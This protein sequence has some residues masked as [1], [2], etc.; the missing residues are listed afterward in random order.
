[1]LKKIISKIKF[2]EKNKGFFNEFE[3][4]FWYLTFPWH[5][6]QFKR[7]VC[8]GM[9]DCTINLVSFGNVCEKSLKIGGF[10][11]LSFLNRPFWIFLF[12]FFL[13]HFHENQSKFLEY[14]GWIKIFMI[15]LASS[16]K[17]QLR[18][19]MQHSVHK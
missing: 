6:G 5:L 9:A 13:L 10:E 2:D 1:M 18:K 15:T 17:Q 16:P 3:K 4:N 11:N 7:K 14:Q 12:N 8:F 19:H